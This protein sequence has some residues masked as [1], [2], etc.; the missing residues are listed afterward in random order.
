MERPK[1]KHGV[2]LFHLVASSGNQIFSQRTEGETHIS[3]LYFRS[4]T[5]A[6]M[7]KYTH[8]HTPKHILYNVSCTY[9]NSYLK[10]FPHSQHGLLYD[11]LK[12]LFQQYEFSEQ[13]DCRKKRTDEME[14]II[15]LLTECLCCS[16][17]YWRAICG[18]GNRVSTYIHT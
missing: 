18:H 3:Y 4:R 10:L 15:A 16:S 8:T 12:S 14:T 17:L 7:R 6:R 5:H 11:L 2:V 9:V 1:W 13:S